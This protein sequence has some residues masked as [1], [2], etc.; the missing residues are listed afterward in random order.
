[1]R[2]FFLHFSFPLVRHVSR[3]NARRRRRGCNRF[4]A[5]AGID[6]VFVVRPVVRRHTIQL[7]STSRRVC[8]TAFIFHHE[9]SLP[10]ARRCRGAGANVANVAAAVLHEF[11]SGV[12]VNAIGVRSLCATREQQ[13]PS[14][15]SE[16]KQHAHR[17]NHCARCS[18]CAS[19]TRSQRECVQ[20]HAHALSSALSLCLKCTHSPVERGATE[21]CACTIART[22]ESLFMCDGE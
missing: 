13:V 15:A 19:R 11:A 4:R 3:R 16:I 8:L 6:C 21:S 1:M 5:R 18:P 14:N 10:F 22:R 12:F 9:T 17:F 7:L 20:H 2:V